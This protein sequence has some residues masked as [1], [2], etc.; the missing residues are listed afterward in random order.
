MG[1]EPQQLRELVGRVVLI[2]EC[3]TFGTK[4]PGGRA[5][6]GRDRVEG[7][8]PELVQDVV[9]AAGRLRAIVSRARRQ[10][11]AFVVSTGGIGLYPFTSVSSNLEAANATT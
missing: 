2:E 6:A 3:R 9:G 7:G 1:W 4:A 10:L 5:S 8:G 11:R